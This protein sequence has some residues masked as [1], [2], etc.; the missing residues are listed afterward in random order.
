MLTVDLVHVE[1]LSSPRGPSRLDFALFVCSNAQ[2]D[3]SLP[4]QSFSCAE[5]PASVCSP[6]YLELFSL[7]SDPVHIGLLLSA[8]S[9]G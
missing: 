3:S 4:L 2:L 1:P 6:A 5:L 8:Q 7:V 9:F